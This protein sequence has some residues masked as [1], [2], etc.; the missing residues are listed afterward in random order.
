MNDIVI[1]D[2]DGTITNIDVL[3][4]ILETY[5]SNDDPIQLNSVN[6]KEQHIETLKHINNLL[7][8]NPTILD[9]ITKK[10]N[11]IIDPYFE[12]VLQ[13]CRNKKTDICILSNG[14]DKIIQYYLPYFDKEKIIAHASEKNVLNFNENLHPKSKYIDMFLRSKYDHITYVGDGTSD[15]SVI[16]HVDQLFVKRGSLLHNKCINDNIKYDSFNDFSDVIKCV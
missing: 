2:F 4:M 12:S 6:N 14:L 16:N 10:Y 9:V 1:C 5:V 11:V 7:T 15:Y 8:N 13:H 3:D